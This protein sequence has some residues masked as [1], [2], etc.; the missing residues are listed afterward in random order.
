M[1]DVTVTVTRSAGP[2]GAV[3]VFIDT[4]FEPHGE[5]GGPGLRVRVNDGKVFAGKQMTMPDPT[6][7]DAEAGERTLRVN[8]DQI[9]YTGTFAK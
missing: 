4:G 8:L 3:V 6:V 7:G 1:S 5:D 2:D 9:A